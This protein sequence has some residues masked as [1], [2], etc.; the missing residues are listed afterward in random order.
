[1]EA[2]IKLLRPFNKQREIIDH[3]ARFKVLAIGRQWGKSETALNDGIPRLLQGQMIWFCS[4]TNKN[5]KRMYPK[6]KQA[7]QNVPGVYTNDSDMVVRVPGGG[8]IQFVSLEVS[9]NLR[10]EG[11]QGMACHIL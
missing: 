11:L 8:F 2:T 4:P 7:L 6:F 9:D 10:G 1:M 3:P 5:N